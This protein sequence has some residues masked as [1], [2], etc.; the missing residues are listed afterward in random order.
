M[1]HTI[2]VPLD[3]SRRAEAILPHARSL[4]QHYEAHVI[5]LLVMEEH[6]VQ[7]PTKDEGGEKAQSASEDIQ[8]RQEIARSYLTDLREQLDDAG[9]DARVRVTSGKPVEEIIKVADH[10]KVDLIAIASHGR[11]ALAQMMYGSVASAVLERVNLPLLMIRSRNI[12]Y[13]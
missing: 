10:E 7:K 4:A 8:H 2:L 5:L 3:G 12:A 9:I 6:P 11:T 13:Q 1:Y